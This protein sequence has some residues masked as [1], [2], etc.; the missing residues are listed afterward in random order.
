MECIED[1]ILS[2][3]HFL[4]VFMLLSF[5]HGY[6]CILKSYLLKYL[7]VSVMMPAVYLQIDQQKDKSVWVFACA[8]IVV[9][10]LSEAY[11]FVHCTV[12]SPFP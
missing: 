11:A 2:L 12:L 9:M 6:V 5:C 1:S 8:Y 3:L 10:N 4:G 7:G